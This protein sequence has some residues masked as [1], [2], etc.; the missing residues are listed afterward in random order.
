MIQSL[1]NLDMQFYKLNVS[2]AGLL[3]N[4]PYYNVTNVL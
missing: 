2:S 4:N 1:I 3:I